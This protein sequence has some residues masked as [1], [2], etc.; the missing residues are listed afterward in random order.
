M[1]HLLECR[2]LVHNQAW[3]LNTLFFELCTAPF[4]L[5]LEEDWMYMDSSVVEQT[6]WRRHAGARGLAA[7]ETLAKNGVKAFD[8]RPI[9]G[10][11]LR[12]ET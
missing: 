11:F 2:L 1:L 7:T 5:I 10:A 8:G 6:S 4:V 12:P 3:G 9:M